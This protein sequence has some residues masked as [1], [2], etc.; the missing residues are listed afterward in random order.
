[1]SSGIDERIGLIINSYN[2]NKASRLRKQECLSPIGVWRWQGSPGP[3]STKSTIDAAIDMRVLTEVSKATLEEC[4]AS[5]SEY[6]RECKL[7][8]IHNSKWLY[9]W[10]KPTLGEE[11]NG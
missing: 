10:L 4:A 5:K 9:D 6:V 11:K 3:L 8:I 1:M 2:V 7:W